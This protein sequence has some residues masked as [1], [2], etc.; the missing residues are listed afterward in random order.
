[1]RRTKREEITN[2]GYIVDVQLIVV[3]V[4]DFK[5]IDDKVG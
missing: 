3:K 4:F 5:T 1:M 2:N